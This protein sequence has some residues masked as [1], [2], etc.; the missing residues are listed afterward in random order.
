V[1]RLQTLKDMHQQETNRLEAHQCAGQ[2][3]LIRSVQEHLHWLRTNI[4]ELQRQIDDHINGHPQLRHNAELLGSIP[5]LGDITIAKFLAYVGDVR[6]FRNARALAAFIG[7]TPRL[8]QSGSSQQGRT[9]LSRTGHAALRHALYMPGLV[10]LR[11]N[12][13][14]HDFGQRLRASGLAPKAVVAAA[15]RKLVHLIFGVMRSG[16]AFDPAIAMPRLDT[17]DGI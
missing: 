4:D 10:A 13:V 8:R 6:R 7:V 5:G 14:I 1:D 17:Q 16:R 11:H 15:M 2:L 9:T 3:E 12:P